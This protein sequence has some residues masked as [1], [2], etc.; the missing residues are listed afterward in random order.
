M[1]HS[2]CCLNNNRGGGTLSNNKYLPAEGNK[3][4]TRSDQNTDK[5]VVLSHEK[6]FHLSFDD[7]ISLFEDLT[8]NNYKSVFQNDTLKW[9]KKLHDEYGV[10]VS[11][12]CFY[13]DDGFD[14]S[15]VPVKYKN[16]F[17]ANSDWLRFGF[18]SLN[19]S[20]TYGGKNSY[21]TDTGT[22]GND[23]E[24]TIKALS[25]IVG[26]KSI[27]NVV[28]LSSFQGTAEE[29]EQLTSSGN[30]PITGLLTADDARQSYF[31]D[32]K[33]NN[34]IYDHDELEQDELTFFS[35]DL[36]V[37]FVD[38]VDEKI[39]EF[40]NTSW[41]NQLQ[42]MIV[43]THEWELDSENKQK[44]E[45]L[46]KWAADDGYSFDFPEDIIAIDIN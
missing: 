36:R 42:D 31:L 11:F 16:E 28:R 43:F 26:E 14:L 32:D 33:D 38:N 13:E 46:I 15:K 30:Q 21:G 41:N 2:N 7:T 40:S 25:N 12:Y 8:I 6:F 29:V 24:Q 5:A 18:H 35:T 45:E 1:Y 37:E 17:E 44:T 27:D 9:V 19:S 4:V 20:T 34:Y 23:Y 3:S 10:K 22:I 39:K